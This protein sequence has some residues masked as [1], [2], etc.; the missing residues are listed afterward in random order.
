LN[1]DWQILSYKANQAL[2]QSTAVTDRSQPVL[3]GLNPDHGA[4]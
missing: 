3:N 4:P 1:K 2:S